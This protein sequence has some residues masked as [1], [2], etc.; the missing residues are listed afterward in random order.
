MDAHATCIT[1][2]GCT[3]QFVPQTGNR[4]RNDPKRV[5]VSYTYVTCSSGKV[6]SVGREGLTLQ[7]VR[8]PAIKKQDGSALLLPLL[9]AHPWV[10][11]WDVWPGQRGRCLLKLLPFGRVICCQ[12]SGAASAAAVK[13]P[14]PVQPLL[15]R[16]V[17]REDHIG[18]VAQRDLLT[19][20]NISCEND[21]GGAV[22]IADRH[23]CIRAARVVQHGDAPKEAHASVRV[24]KMVCR[25][26]VFWRV[27]AT[28][29]LQQVGLP[30]QSSEPRHTRRPERNLMDEQ[31]PRQQRAGSKRAA[32]RVS[33]LTEM[34]A[35]VQ[36]QHRPTKGA[37][38]TGA[39][40]D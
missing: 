10:H 1:V 31:A 30:C 29:S 22:G 13:P 38:S 39:R 15:P 9:L 34:V 18:A 12:M 8:Q 19:L 2:F 27:T 23:T 5:I 6:L 35:V 28:E 11:R 26:D 3:V 20:R 37:T 24:D 21:A 32:S 25:D 36:R 16:L 14:A 40:Q 7:E 17:W 4:K 33:R